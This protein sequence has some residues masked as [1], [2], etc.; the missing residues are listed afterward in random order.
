MVSFNEYSDLEFKV[1]I[2]KIMKSLSSTSFFSIGLFSSGP[3]EIDNTLKSS[4]EQIYAKFNRYGSDF[5]LKA[6][7]TQVETHLNIALNQILIEKGVRAF[8][9]KPTYYDKKLKDSEGNQ[10]YEMD[11]AGNHVEK[12]ERVKAFKVELKSSITKIPKEY[13]KYDMSSEYFD[14]KRAAENAI[15]SLA[16][17]Y[18]GFS[19]NNP[20]GGG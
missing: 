4:L 6:A 5:K 2:Q 11:V 12:T 14:S 18:A 17:S 13:R 19:N 16:T 3:S 7:C 1:A 9:I 15:N 10:I 8:D 20:S